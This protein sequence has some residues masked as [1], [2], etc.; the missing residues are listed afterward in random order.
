MHSGQRTHTV[1]LKVSKNYYE[2][3]TISFSVLN[4]IMIR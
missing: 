3:H 4:T 1:K 2:Q